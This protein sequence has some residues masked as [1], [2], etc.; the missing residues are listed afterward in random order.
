[1]TGETG[2]R[3]QQRRWWQRKT[4]FFL[5]VAVSA[6]ITLYFVAIREWTIAAIY[7]AAAAFYA[8]LARKRYAR[9]GRPGRQREGRAAVRR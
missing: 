1:M 3:P 5:P 4:Y 9:Y 2:S 6:A 7:G 8:W